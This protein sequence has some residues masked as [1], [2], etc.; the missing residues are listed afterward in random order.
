M[1]LIT[2]SLDSNWPLRALFELTAGAWGSLRDSWL[3]QR[4]GHSHSALTVGATSW[5]R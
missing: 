1:M 4:I 5:G 3:H 2:Q